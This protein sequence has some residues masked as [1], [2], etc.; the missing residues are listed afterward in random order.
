MNKFLVKIFFFLLFTFIVNEIIVRYFYLVPDIPEREIDN[1]G[2]QRYKKNQEGYYSEDVQ[3]KVNK[4]GWIGVSNMKN[5]TIFSIIGDSYIENLMNPIECHQGSILGDS[6]LNISFFEAGRS[7]VTFI[8]AIEIS[9]ILN[10]EVSPTFQLIYLSDEDF[11][12]SISDIQRYSDRMQISIR[13]N[14]IEK[15]EIKFSLLKKIL[16]NIKTLYYLYLNFPIFV[17]E[18]NKALMPKIDNGKDKFNETYFTS[19]FEY[20][21]QN[22]D[23]NRIV[24]VFRPNTDKRFLKLSEKFKV[25]FFSLKNDNKSDWSMSESDGHWSCHG[26]KQVA[27]QVINNLYSLNLIE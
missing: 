2:I 1:F 13:K 6:L 27:K 25:K 12:E 4:Y 22:Y 26:H 5:E 9:D 19:L 11:Y 15:S 3:W 18:Q 23:L 7:G 16:Y 24:F 14:K 8:E 20:C 21:N 10:Q 17:E